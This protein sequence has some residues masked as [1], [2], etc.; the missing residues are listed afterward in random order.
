[1]LASLARVMRPGAAL[2][3]ATDIPDYADMVVAGIAAQPAFAARPGLLAERP[4]D[5]PV[6]RYEQKALAAGREPQ[7]FMFQRV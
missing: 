2:R 1:V 6:T 3:F 4:A 5:W 7:F